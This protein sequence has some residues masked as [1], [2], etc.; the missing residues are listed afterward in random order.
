ML[1]LLQAYILGKNVHQADIKLEIPSFIYSKQ[2]EAIFILLK[3]EC[4]NLCK[5][6]ITIHKDI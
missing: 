4:N 1:F 6:K 2:L 5:E 3:S